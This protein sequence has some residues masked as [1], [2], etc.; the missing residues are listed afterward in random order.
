M[1]LFTYDDF[2][3]EATKAGLLDTF[4]TSD[5]KIA[6]TDADAGMAILGY[7]QQ[8]NKAATDEERQA[9]HD[10][11]ETVRGK[12]GYTGGVE[13]S[14]FNPAPSGTTAGRSTDELV[15]EL[16]N[17]LYG[18]RFSYDPNTDASYQA[19]KA[20]LEAQRKLGVEDT[21]G[22]YSMNTGGRASTAAVSAA[23]QTS[24]QYSRLIADALAAAE[25]RKYEQYSADQS[26]TGSLL[27]NLYSK[28][29]AK[30]T[31]KAEAQAKTEAAAAAEAASAKE[32]ENTAY[33]RAY[34]IAKELADLGYPS[35]M[36][37]LM[38]HGSLNGFKLSEAEQTKVNKT[39]NESNIAT[40]ID[41][42][43]PEE[44][45]RYNNIQ[46]AYEATGGNY[47]VPDMRD[48]ELLIKIFG[49]EEVL[50]NYGLYSY[51]DL[52]KNDLSEGAYKRK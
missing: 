26:N 12:Y 15:T 10:A 42:L 35:A 6:E 41:A 1:A 47:F 52:D 7:K 22:A 16:E 5:L 3:K 19:K 33:K 50:N 13:G 20:E 37:Y 51:Q 17:K 45:A 23:Q 44:A 31:A 43:T 2:L 27:N 39:V 40:N 29:A 21:L 25:R 34:D 38:E 24:E 36:Y 9:A 32:Q 28:Q 18:G 14:G 48:W 30:Q 11:A 4:S 49:S 8:Y 46:A